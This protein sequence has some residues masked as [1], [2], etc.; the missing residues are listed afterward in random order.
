MRSVAFP[1]FLVLIGS[2]HSATSLDVP[3]SQEDLIKSDPF[4]FG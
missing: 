2:R 4:N 3:L 1:L